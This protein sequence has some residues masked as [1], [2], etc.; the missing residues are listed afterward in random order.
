MTLNKR[1]LCLIAVAFVAGTMSSSAKANGWVNG[2]W[3]YPYK[4]FLHDSTGGRPWAANQKVL[5]IQD[6]SITN[7]PINH[8]GIGIG[9]TRLPNGQ[10]WAW[11]NVNILHCEIA[12]IWRTPGW[13]TDFIQICGGGNWQDNPTDIVLQDIDLHDGVGIPVM[14]QD[15]NFNNIL[16]KDLRVRN[17]GVSLQVTAIHTGHINSITVDHCPN[18][19][20]AV[21]GRPAQWAL[22]M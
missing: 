13:H 7:T 19:S 4:T 14:I 16:M 10:Y 12:G 22:C 3:V 15:G 20:I 9:A 5:T 11:K 1:I 18:M 6:T 8:K 2:F 17:T 21:M